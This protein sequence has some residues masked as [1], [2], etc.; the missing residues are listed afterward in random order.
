[1]VFCAKDSHIDGCGQHLSQAC[2][3][4]A[5]AASLPI[6]RSA[7][8]GGGVTSPPDFISACSPPYL[9]I[10]HFNSQTQPRRLVSDRVCYCLESRTMVPQEAW[11]KIQ[12]TGPGLFWSLGDWPRLQSL[13]RG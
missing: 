7:K 8:L 11:V 13:W 1:M 10:R 3:R 5:I 2:L 6:K 4:L 12:M 9:A